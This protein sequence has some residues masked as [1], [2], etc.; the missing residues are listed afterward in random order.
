MASA[1][2]GLVVVADEMQKAVYGQM[3][4]MIAKR[5]P[6]CGASRAVVS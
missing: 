6:S 1:W 2:V 4:E 3:R 5:L